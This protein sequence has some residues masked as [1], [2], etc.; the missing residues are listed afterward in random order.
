LSVERKTPSE[1]TSPL[2]ATRSLL[3]VAVF[4]SLGLVNPALANWWIVRS[5]DGQCLIV[6]IEPTGSGVTK[7]GKEFY[8]TQEQAEVDAKRLC[9]EAK[10]RVPH[11]PRKDN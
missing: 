6:D 3:F 10:A 4:F 1:N 8:Q 9:A 7:M 5:A 11:E 2:S